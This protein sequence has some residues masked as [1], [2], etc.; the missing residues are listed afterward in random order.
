VEEAKQEPVVVA[1]RIAA[2]HRVH[3]A[4]ASL[5]LQELRNRL[6]AEE[7]AQRRI[8]IGAAQDEWALAVAGG[9]RLAVA[10]RQRI[11]WRGV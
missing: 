4:G 11:R 2:I 8:D 5:G 1:N 9:H 3:L 10:L 6:G 7:A